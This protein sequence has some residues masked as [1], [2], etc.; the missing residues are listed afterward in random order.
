MLDEPLMPQFII[1]ELNRDPNGLL[2]M[3]DRGQGGRSRF[4]HL[5]EEAL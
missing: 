2:E 3:I 1:S 5:V 4:L